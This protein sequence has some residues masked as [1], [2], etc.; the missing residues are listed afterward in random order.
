MVDL[1]SLRSLSRRP[2]THTSQYIPDPS[3][4]RTLLVPHMGRISKV[5]ITPTPAQLYAS[6][7]KLFPPLKPGEKLG[8]NK[9][10]WAMLLA[11]LRV[12]FP[13]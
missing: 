5:R 4:S 2:A 13:R 9:R 8:V 3:G 6:H 12:A 7:L 10:F 11:V 1:V